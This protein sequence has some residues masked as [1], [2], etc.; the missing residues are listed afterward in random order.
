M[1]IGR[2]SPWNSTP[3]SAIAPTFQLIP[4]KIL[5][6]SFKH[7]LQND[8]HWNKR[9]KLKNAASSVGYT[10]KLWVQTPSPQ[11]NTNNP[12]SSTY[13]DC[14]MTQTLKLPHQHHNRSDSLKGQIPG[15]SISVINN[16][17]IREIDGDSEIKKNS[18][19][20]KKTNA[21]PKLRS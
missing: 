10:K 11:N 19:E 3:S 15:R 8:L 12:T 1:F 5:C 2:K 7:L 17:L 14:K 21:L 20:G 16:L 18:N 6:K 9:H 13:K 4:H